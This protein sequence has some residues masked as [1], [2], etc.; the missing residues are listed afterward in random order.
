ML[1]SALMS[2]VW[3]S[4]FHC[5]TNSVLFLKL[6]RT[7]VQLLANTKMFFG[8]KHSSVQKL[9][10]AVA[11]WLQNHI[12]PTLANT[13]VRTYTHGEDQIF[14]IRTCLAVAGECDVIHVLW[15]VT[16][17]SQIILPSRQFY[18]EHF[19]VL[20]PSCA[21][22]GYCWIVVLTACCRC[23]MSCVSFFFFVK[24]SFAV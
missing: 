22:T 14:P 3:L 12:G 15:H 16:M 24:V 19:I 2:V 13:H 20:V 1:R 18:W 21:F 9:N 8:H 11:Y 7:K 23:M 5:A 6:I 10:L 17:I 4:E